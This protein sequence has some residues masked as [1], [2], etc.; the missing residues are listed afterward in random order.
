MEESKQPELHTITVD[1][2]DVFVIVT[3]GFTDQLGGEKS[4]S[5]SYGYRR[6][7]RLLA[8]FTN[9]TAEEIAAQMKDD[10]YRWQGENK[11]RDDVTA[12]VFRL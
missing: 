9:A 3:D 4:P 2:G 7:E 6:L 12:V 1:D 5:V 10:L 11:R 8:N